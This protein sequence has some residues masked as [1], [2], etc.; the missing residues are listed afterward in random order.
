[1]RVQGPLAH[2]HTTYTR[3]S[4]KAKSFHSLLSGKEKVEKFEQEAGYVACDTGATCQIPSIA[5][6][7]L[8]LKALTPDRH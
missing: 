3:T 6:V 4:L 7:T 8:R 2:S 1:M 5:P